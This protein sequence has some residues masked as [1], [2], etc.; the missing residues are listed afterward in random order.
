MPRVLSL[1][2]LCLCLVGWVRAEGPGI[3]AVRVDPPSLE[4]SAPAARYAILV[5][6]QTADGRL[7]DLTRQAQ[8]RSLAPPVVQVETDGVVRALSDGVTTVEVSAA[9]QKQTIAV[10][11]RNAAA[12]RRFNFENDIVPILSRHGCN[13]SGCHGKAEGQNGFKLSVFGFDPA[14]DYDA[15]TKEG[16]G[17]RVFPAAAERSLLLAKASGGAPHGGGVRISHDSLEYATLRDWIAAGLPRGR[18]DDPKVISIE[19]APRERVLAA[20]PVGRISNPSVNPANAPSSGSA[21][22]GSSQQLRVIARYSDGRTADVTPLAKFQTNNDALATV[23]DAGLVTAGQTP[24]QVAVMAS[25]LGA[26]DAFRALIPRA[27]QTEKGPTEKG[28]TVKPSYP[29]EHNFIDRHVH[30]QLRKL[31]IVPSDVTD[32]ATYLRRVFLDVIGTLPT[33]AEART[34]LADK[35]ADKRTRLVDELLK[36]PEYADY[37]ALLWADLL[38]VDRQAL[39]HK[40]AYAYYRW[41]RESFARNRPLDQFA[42][43]LLTAEGPL[44]EAPA[45]N[46]FRVVAKPGEMASTWSQVF[47]GVRI[48]CAECHH[49]PFDRWSQDDYYGMVGHFTQVRTKK[50]PLGDVLFA[51]GEVVTT[52][53]RTGKAVPPTPLGAVDVGGRTDFQSVRV[54]TK[55]E[56]TD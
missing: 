28:P 33:A 23:S 18:D 20:A 14:A 29:A 37:Q 42:R 13:S 44:A 56:R 36:R 2:W 3:V 41:I 16:R 52:N 35:R 31:N 1:G 49:H 6:G 5:E 12:A 30:D 8:F 27:E 11:V 47:L 9:G 32:D 22:L 4:L 34:L 26:V 19:I 53:P 55:H 48:A 54:Q 43:E 39:G 10:S 15:L 25:Y 17:R 51:A 38:R 40:Q 45:G 21:A 24:G 46:F 7:V 50:S